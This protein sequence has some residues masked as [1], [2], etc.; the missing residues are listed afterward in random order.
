MMKQVIDHIFEE[1]EYR[2]DEAWID[3]K[4]PKHI[5]IL[6]EVLTENGWGSIKH[7]LIRNLTEAEEDE[8]YSHKGQGIYVKKGDEEN[9]DAQTFS[10]NT[11]GAS[12]NFRGLSRPLSMPLP[13]QSVTMATDASFHSISPPMLKTS[14]V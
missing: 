9:D 8:K 4:N 6:S 12:R 3:W 13:G 7:E 10:A 5:S 14:Q 2:I 11:G 1:V